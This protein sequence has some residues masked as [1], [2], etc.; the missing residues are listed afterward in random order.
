MAFL[1]FQ[2]L[3][4]PLF[5][6]ICILTV[7]VVAV[8]RTTYV[9]IDQPQEESQIEKLTVV[10]EKQNLG[11]KVQAS[12]TVEPIQNVNI[13]PKNPGILARLMVE[14]GDLVKQGQVLAVMENAQIQAQGLQAQAHVN[15]ALANLE[16]AQVRI[17]GELNQSKARAIQAQA[18]L[19]EITKQIPKD[20]DQAKA[21]V[22]EAQSR[23]ELAKTR[24]ERYQY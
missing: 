17:Q 3:K 15:E 20:I 16:K 10:V 21:K 11:V 14:Q 22:V 7:G 4:N 1:K 19:E 12:G 8:A 2:T 9:M 6:L 5:W 24:L 18:R 23:F 13:S